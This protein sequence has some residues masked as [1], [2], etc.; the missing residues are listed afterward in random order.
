MTARTVLITGAGSGIGQAAAARFA[1]LGYRVAIC[2]RGQQNLRATMALLPDDALWFECDVSD[3]AQV[4]AMFAAIQESWGHLD[5]LVN[6]AARYDHQAPFVDLTDEQ[7]E[8]ILQVNVMGVVRCSRAAARLMTPAG[9]GRIINLTALQRERPIPGWSAYAASKAAISTITR[10]MAVELS[11]AGI[12]VNAVEPGAIAAWVSPDE[13]DGTSASLLRRMGR[14][15]EVARVISFLASDD[16]GFVVGETIRVDG[17]RMLMPR[18]DPQSQT[19]E[20]T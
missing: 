19:Q 6:N 15:E 3:A 1:E 16:A 4:D 9:H 14:P 10:S 12:V 11:P 8:Q 17:G 2:G 7:W 18:P 20:R 5:V 13:I